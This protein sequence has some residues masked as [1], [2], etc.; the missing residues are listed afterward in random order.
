MTSNND[1]SQMRD[2]VH[3]TQ[4]EERMLEYLNSKLYI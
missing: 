2:G 1:F 4:T 3:L